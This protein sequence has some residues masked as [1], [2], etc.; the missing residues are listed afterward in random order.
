MQVDGLAFGQA[1]VIGVGDL[2]GAFFGTLAAG[3]AFVHIHEPRVLSQADLKI[4][5]FAGNAAHLGK[6]Q[7]FD[8]DIP[9]DLDQLGRDNSHGA[10]IGGE[11]FIQL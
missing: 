11:C 1:A 6:R 3:D 9:A 8:I 10:V 2:F 5:R 7:Q 4:S